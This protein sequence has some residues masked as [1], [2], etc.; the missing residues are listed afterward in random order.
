MLI[1]S[2]VLGEEGRAAPVP[3]PYADACP[4]QW[5]YSRASS[6]GAMIALVLVAAVISSGMLF[7]GHAVLT[8]VLV[9]VVAG[10]VVAAG[11]YVLADR[12]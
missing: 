7:R 8:A 9:G 2:R 1:P 5:L 4:T 3:S 12:S 11:R 6:R 10:A